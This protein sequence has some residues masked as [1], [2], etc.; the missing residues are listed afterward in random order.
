VERE[1]SSN[2]RRLE[3]ERG[4]KRPVER[5]VLSEAPRQATVL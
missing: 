2:A 4:A 1:A 3:T 5:E